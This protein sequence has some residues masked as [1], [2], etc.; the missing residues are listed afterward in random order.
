[1]NQWK[2]Y[3]CYKNQASSSEVGEEHFA[4][5]H[6]VT[7]TVYCMLASISQPGEAMEFIFPVDWH[8]L[9][10]V[11]VL[12][13]PIVR[14]MSKYLSI[15]RLTPRWPPR[16]SLFPTSPCDHIYSRVIYWLYLLISLVAGIGMGVAFVA[17]P[18]I[19]GHYF[20]K[21]RSLAIN[22]A[23]IGMNYIIIL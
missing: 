11:A 20:E 18:V 15:S 10:L 3:A 2:L 21:R 5:S 7:Y 1:M 14:N 4:N 22:L 13:W 12:W 19:I 16:P 6:F 8:T 17:T 23:S 9:P